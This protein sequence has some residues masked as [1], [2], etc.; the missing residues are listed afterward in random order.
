MLDDKEIIH[1]PHTDST[2]LFLI[3]YQYLD[4]FALKTWPEA[5]TY[6]FLELAF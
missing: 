4:E 1:P 2:S 3:L 5:L 6:G